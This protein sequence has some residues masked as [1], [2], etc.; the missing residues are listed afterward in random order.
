MDIDVEAAYSTRAAEYVNLV[1]SMDSVHPSDRH[2]VS[3]WATSL[4]GPL[5]DAGC[6]PGQWT[7]YLA[8]LGCDVRG[9]DLSPTFVAHARKT[10]PGRSFG[11][12]T[13]AAIEAD[14]SSVAGVLAWYSMIHQDPRIGPDCL[15]EFARVIRTGGGLLLGFFEGDSVETF[16]HAVVTAYRWP[17]HAMAERVESAG[18]R[19]S[20]T[21]TRTGPGYRPHGAITA[22]RR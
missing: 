6:G 14:T 9:I 1:G 7:N 3:D 22:I 18:F 15:L 10:Y 21:F 17:V 11:V 16:D 12:G 2:L 13:M 20:E 19:V 8:G 4:H 5:I